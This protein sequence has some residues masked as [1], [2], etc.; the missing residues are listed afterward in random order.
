MATVLQRLTLDMKTLAVILVALSLLA[1][2]AADA[3]RRRLLYVAH[4]RG[5]AVFDI[6]AGHKLVKEIPG[7]T[8]LKVRGIAGHAGTGR[9]YVSHYGTTEAH[10]GG[11]LVAIDLASDRVV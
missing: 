3:A 4:D 8:L 11:K 1:P 10:G 6:D 2:A 9:L 7:P 5:I